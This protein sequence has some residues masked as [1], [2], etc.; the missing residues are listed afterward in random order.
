[1]QAILSILK[2]RK[3]MTRGIVYLATR[4]HLHSKTSF[5]NKSVFISFGHNQLDLFQS[6]PNWAMTI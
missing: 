2:C 3:E 1:M 4:V 5:L 6:K